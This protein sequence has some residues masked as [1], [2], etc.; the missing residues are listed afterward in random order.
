MKISYYLP[1]N[2]L[3]NEYLAKSVENT[4]LANEFTAQKIYEKSG[5]KT[6]FIAD[7]GEIVSHM[8]VKAANKLFCEY[9]IDKKN[10]DF[11]ILCTENP[12]YIFPATAFIV[13]EKLGLGKQTGAFDINVGCSGYT[14]GLAIA[15]GLIESGSAKKVLFCTCDIQAS[16]NKNAK[17]AQRIIFSDAASATLLDENNIQKIG[18]FIFGSDGN[19]FYSMYSKYGGMAYP[20]NKENHNEVFKNDDVEI[21]MNGSEIVLFS[22]RE[23]PIMVKNILAANNLTM[24]DI[25]FF[26][27]HQ[28][29]MLILKTLIK[30]LNIPAKKMILD[31]EEI[32]NTS[33]SSIAITLKRAIENDTIKSGSKILIAGYGVGL[34]WSGSILKI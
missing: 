27:F 12:D 19:G 11:I 34:S 22:L 2:T 4:D 6:R 18:K 28:S 7:D 21:N 3:S 26:I 1:N 13:H 9:N 24:N 16:I 14:H 23:V 8:C 32:G 25:D 5:I 15:K 17:I 30:M 29:N 33:S 20:I 10:I 31:I